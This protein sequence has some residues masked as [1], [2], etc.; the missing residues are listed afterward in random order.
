MFSFKE[1]DEIRGIH[2]MWMR[3]LNN[4]VIRN[5]NLKKFQIISELGVGSQAKVYK[6]CRQSK[7]YIPHD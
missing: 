4:W 1:I 2:K 6:I 7:P 5:E 3:A